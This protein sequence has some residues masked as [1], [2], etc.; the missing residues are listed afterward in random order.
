MRR[1]LELG[2][3]GEGRT[4][5][6]PAVG[7]VIVRQGDIVGEG[8]HPRA[9]EG[10]A[11]IFALRQ[12]AGAARGGDL[13][14]TLE[15]C[16]HQG[17]TG[18]CAE[19]VIAAGLARVFIGTRDPNPRVD[20]G[21]ISRLQ[22]AG[23]EVITGILEPECR[24]LIAPFAKHVTTGLP[25]VTLKAAMTLEG[26]IATVSGDSRWISG[27]ESRLAV[28]RLRDRVDAIM[29][30]IGTVLQDDPRLTTRLPAAEGRDPMRIVVDAELRIPETAAVLAPGSG[31]PTLVATTARA[32]K[33]K[34]ERLQRRGIQLLEV[35]DQQQGRVDLPQLL[36]Q[37]GG[38]GI[39]SILLE[40]GSRLNAAALAA[41]I[42]DRVMIFVAPLLL[43]GSEGPGIFA[44]PG[45]DNL[46]R[47]IRLQ[48]LRVERCGDDT[49]IEGEVEPCS[50]V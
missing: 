38:M 41:G 30:G 40:G 20:G 22:G 1:A 7:A 18:P 2:R 39:Q 23:I 26:R 14:V 36:Q 24:R 45:V 29:V 35:G 47:A 8:Y 42:V 31:A 46:A 49:L 28:H 44:G 43:G 11:A 48:Q 37:L 34:R 9:G 12:A 16:C 6:N 10:H 15:P 17:R 50:P 19:A 13:Y 33:E 4:R 32:P 3:R 21:G 27:E 5:P 25:H